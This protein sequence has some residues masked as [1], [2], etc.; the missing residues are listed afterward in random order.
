MVIKVIGFR[1]VSFRDQQSGDQ[2]VGK[3]MYYIYQDKNVEG[4][5]ADKLFIRE[6]NPNPFSVGKRYQVSY[7][8]YGK[9]DLEQVQEMS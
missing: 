6:G 3:S 8:R 7:N 2:I 9:F 1:N 5:A 4:N